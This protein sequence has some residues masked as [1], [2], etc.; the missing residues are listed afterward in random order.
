MINIKSLYTVRIVKCMNSFK[1]LINIDET[2]FSRAMRNINSWSVKVKEWTLNNIWCSNSFTLI[3]AI[4]SKITVYASISSNTVKGSTFAKI[5]KEL[6]V[7][8]EERLKVNTKE[9]LII[10]KNA[11]T[12]HSKIVS[13]IIHEK[14]LWVAFIP[15]Y[16]PKL[17]LIERYFAFLKSV[18][19]KQVNITTIN[20][21]K[22]KNQCIYKKIDAIN[23]FEG[24]N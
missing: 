7:F 12:H 16:S 10:I 15:A 22:R 6:K 9:W 24:S 21:K 8:I 3:T 17:A 13:D 19:L 23:T 14:K 5:L 4:L 11:P 20:W 1:I 18:I 2:L